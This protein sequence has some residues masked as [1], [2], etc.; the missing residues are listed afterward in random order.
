MPTLSL[1]RLLSPVRILAT[2]SLPCLSCAVPTSH[3][4]SASHAVTASPPSSPPPPQLAST[5]PSGPQLPSLSSNLRLNRFST[6][7]STFPTPRISQ[8]LTRD[9]VSISSSAFLMSRSLRFWRSLL[10]LPSRLRAV[11]SSSWWRAS[12]G[13]RRRFSAGWR[14]GR[15]LSLAPWWVMVSTSIRSILLENIPRF[16]FSPL[17]LELGERIKLESFTP[18]LIVHRLSWCSMISVWSSLKV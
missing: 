17:D 16:W 13:Q 5:P 14:E 3:A 2:P 4:I 7:R 12:L 11:R 15:P 8:L 6:S 10:L 9:P 18:S 1:S